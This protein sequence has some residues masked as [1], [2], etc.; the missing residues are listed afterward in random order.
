MTR[1]A[2]DVTGA[3]GGETLA[4]D[5]WQAGDSVLVDQG[6]H[7]PQVILDRFARE[8]GASVRLNP[9][10]MPWFARSGEAD[11]FDPAAV[12]LEVAASLRACTDDTIRLP[13]WRRAP[14]ASGPGWLSAVRLPPEAA[15]AARRRCRKTARRQGRTPSDATRFLAGWVMV[16]TTVAPETLDG[17]TVLALYRCRWPVELAFKRLPSRLDLD[18]LRT[19]QNSR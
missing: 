1:H 13:V 5:P 12:R 3:D 15:E 11:V 19:Q 6:D 9:T 14:Q 7:Q 17:P 2:V 18:T 8:V 16:F 4:R 10:A